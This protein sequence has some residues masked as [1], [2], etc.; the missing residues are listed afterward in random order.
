MGTNSAA[1]ATPL[2]PVVSVSSTDQSLLSNITLS[3]EYEIDL[4]PRISKGNTVITI[5]SYNNSQELITVSN[6]GFFTIIE[7]GETLQKVYRPVLGFYASGC[8]GKENPNP[9]NIIYYVQEYK[10]CRSKIPT[11]FFSKR[12]IENFC[13]IPLQT[14]SRVGGADLRITERIIDSSTKLKKHC[15][16]LHEISRSV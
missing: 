6:G 8:P 3:E 15:F 16:C 5:E 13:N 1:G 14:L 12:S 2:A 7:L 10:N 4:P 9:G 11:N